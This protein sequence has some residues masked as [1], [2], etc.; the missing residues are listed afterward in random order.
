MDKKLKAV[1]EGA[2]TDVPRASEAAMEASSKFKGAVQEPT[3]AQQAEAEKNLEQEAKRL[4]AATGKSEQE[5]KAEVAAKAEKRKWVVKFESIPEGPFYRPKR[6][7]TQ[8]RLI[9]NTDHPFH[10]KVYEPI[11]P[12]MRSALEVLLFVLA[13]RELEC[14]DDAETFYKAERNRWSE[15][16]RHALEELTP[17]DAFADKAA[18][19]AERMY[20]EVITGPSAP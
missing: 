4:A 3:L 5:T 13:E 7:G 12:D 8:K 17:T 6:L 9:I 16:L 10:S 1:A 19:V 2:S 11:S 18:A 14:R 15:R 20:E